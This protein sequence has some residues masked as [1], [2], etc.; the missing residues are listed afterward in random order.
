MHFSLYMGSERWESRT[1][2]SLAILCFLSVF[3]AP[4]TSWAADILFS[5]DVR[6]IL[7]QKCLTWPRCRHSNV[8]P[9]PSHARRHA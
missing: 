3:V 2:F 6:P 7:E 8:E 4:L 1:G 9:R 5:K